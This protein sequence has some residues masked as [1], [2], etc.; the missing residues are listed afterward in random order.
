[1]TQIYTEQLLIITLIVNIMFVCTFKLFEILY[2]YIDTS[3]P[4]AAPGQVHTQLTS[5]TEL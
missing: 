4:A 2:K 1:M 5:N 3:T